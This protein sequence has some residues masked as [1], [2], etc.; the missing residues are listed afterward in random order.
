MEV[1]RGDTC[2]RPHPSGLRE[3]GLE[4]KVAFPGGANRCW[5]LG[6]D[7][8]S[9]LTDVFGSVMLTGSASFY[10]CYK[11]QSE[12]NVDLRQTYTP[13]SSTEYSSSVD[14]SLFCAPWSTYGDDIKQPSNSQISIKNRVSLCHPVWSAVARS[15]LT[16]TLNSWAQTILLPQPPQ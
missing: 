5:N 14:S 12:D 2:P 1:R 7:A 4:P 11:S 9:R 3:E 13:F 15:W 6:A 10:D 8:G 16:T